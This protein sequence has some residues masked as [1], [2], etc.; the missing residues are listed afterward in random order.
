MTV[1]VAIL[2][3]GGQGGAVQGLQGVNSW[4]G[5]LR[6]LYT[7]TD[8]LTGGTPMSSLSGGLQIPGLGAVSSTHSQRD[9]PSATP[10]ISVSSPNIEVRQEE[11]MIHKRTVSLL[12]GVDIDP[13]PLLLTDDGTPRPLKN[14][15][16]SKCLGRN[17]GSWKLVQSPYESDMAR[18]G[19][20]SACPMRQ[21]LYVTILMKRTRRLPFCLM[22]RNFLSKTPFVSDKIGR[23]V[24]L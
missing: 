13:D 18:K 19:I 22:N 21:A 16:E 4:Q 20:R 3:V 5:V 15:T 7:A 2:F 10:R 9:M 8:S 11:N 1:N 24:Q 23:S 17:V 12:G 6:G 14:A